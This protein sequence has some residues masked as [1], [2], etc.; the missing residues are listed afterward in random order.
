MDEDG[1]TAP[2]ASKSPGLRRFILTEHGL[3]YLKMHGKSV[4]SNECMSPGS[5]S[6]VRESKKLRPRGCS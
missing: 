3:S 5:V 4:V 2:R 1:T 6:V